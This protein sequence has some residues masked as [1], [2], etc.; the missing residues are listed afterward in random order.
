MH[1]ILFQQTNDYNQELE[2]HL[3]NDVN[4]SLVTLKHPEKFLHACV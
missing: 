3:I 1:T 4:I 2:N